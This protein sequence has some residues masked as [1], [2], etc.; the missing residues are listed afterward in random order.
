MLGNTTFSRGDE[1]ELSVWD[2]GT[3]FAPKQQA[4]SPPPKPEFSESPSFNKR[5]HGSKLLSGEL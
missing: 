5:K 4:P 3:A 1:V 2:L